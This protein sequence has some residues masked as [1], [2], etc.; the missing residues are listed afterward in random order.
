LT[1]IMKSS[2]AAL[3]LALIFTTACERHEQAQP[4]ALDTSLPPPVSVADSEITL[5][6]TKGAIR[7]GENLYVS[8][9]ADMVTPDQLKDVSLAE[10]EEEVY[11][12]LPP[13]V[14]SPDPGYRFRWISPRRGVISVNGYIPKVAYRVTLRPGLCDAGGN[15][16]N[17]A[18]WGAELASEDIG[19]S[20]VHLYGGN[21]V[22]LDGFDA[23]QA[24]PALPRARIDFNRDVLPSDVAERVFF[25]DTASSE[26]QPVV[27]CL[28]EWETGRPQGMVFVQPRKPLAVGRRYWLVV[29]RLKAAQGTYETSYLRVYPAGFCA[30]LESNYA[31]GYNQPRVGRFARVFFNQALDPG[32][33]DP[34][35]IEIV[36][37]VPDLKVKAEGLTAVLTGDFK[38]ETEYVIRVA[39]GAPA[40]S[41]VTTSEAKEW[42]ID[43]PERRPS[44]IMPADFLAQRF[45]SGVDINIAH[46]GTSEL[47]WRIAPVP[48]DKLADIRQ[49]LREFALAV[50]DDR[51]QIKL[52]PRDQ[53]IQY[54]STDSL[55]DA[56]QL[57]FEKGVL[58]A[59][60]GEE[61]LSHRIQWKPT[62]SLQL[63][64]LYLLE[65]E[66]QGE[67]GRVCGNRMLLSLSDWFMNFIATRTSRSVR[68]SNLE[69]GAPAAGVSVQACGEDGVVMDEAVTDADGIARF[70]KLGKEDGEEGGAGDKK[71]QP[72]WLLA[73]NEQ[74]RCLQM[75][76]YSLQGGNYWSGSSSPTEVQGMLVSNGML[77]EPGE[78]VRLFAMVRQAG[79]AGPVVPP[80]GFKALIR[81][82]VG[83]DDEPDM[84]TDIRLNLDANG[85]TEAVWPV[86]PD[87]IPSRIYFSLIYEQEEEDSGDLHQI[88]VDVTRF[89]PPAFEVTVDAGPTTGAAAEIELSSHFF[90]GSANRDATATWTA[91]WVMQDWLFEALPEFDYGGEYYDDDD[92]SGTQLRNHTPAVDSLKSLDF[93]ASDNWNLFTFNDRFSP[94]AAQQGLEGVLNSMKLISGPRFARNLAA[95][96]SQAVRGEVK[97]DAEGKAVITCE[98]PF[99]NRA[100]SHRAQVFWTIDVTTEAGQSR[101]A[102]ANQRVQFPEQS[103]AIRSP[104]HEKAQGGLPVAITLIDVH[105]EEVGGLEAEV[106]VFH[107]T[108][109]TVVDRLSETVHRYRNAPEFRTVSKQK[110]RLPFTG[111]LPAD[112]PGD[113]VVR[114]SLM[115]M[116]ESVPASV[117]ITGVKASTELAVVDNTGF[118]A[119]L[120]QEEVPVGENAVIKVRTPFPGHLRITVETGELLET[121]PLVVMNGTES[122]VEVPVHPEYFPNVFVRLHLMKPSSPEEPPAERFALCP[123]TVRHPAIQLS[124]VPRFDK[125]SFQ[126]REEVSGH[127]LVLAGGKPLAKAAVLVFAVDDAVHSLTNWQPPEPAPLFYP[128]RE[129]D[130]RTNLALGRQW[131]M[132]QL[133]ELSQFEKGYILGASREKTLL[134]TIILRENANP[135]PLWQAQVV[136]DEQGR[137]AFSFQAPDSLTSYRV[138]AVAH[139]ATTQ[140]GAGEA[141]VSVSNPLRVEPFLPQFIR[142]G[143]ELLVRCQLTQDAADSAAVAL[144]IEVEGPASLVEGGQQNFTLSKG[145]PLAATARLKAGAAAL[146]SRVR[147]IFKVRTTSGP[148]LADGAIVPLVLLPKFALRTEI[149]TGELPGGSTWQVVESMKTEWTEQ[150]GGVVDVLLS[151][152]KWLPQIYSMAPGTG[153]NGTMADLAS[154]AFTPYLV[155]ELA[156]YLPWRPDA[157]PVSNEDG[158][159]A[160]PLW[161]ARQA[162]ADA[163]DAISMLEDSLIPDDAAGWLPRFPR[164]KTVDDP[165]TALVALAISVGRIN[166]ETTSFLDTEETPDAATANEEEGDAGN[167]ALNSIWSERLLTKL[168]YW[169]EQATT[170]G[171][172]SP[173]MPAPTPFVQSLALLADA[174]DDAQMENPDNLAAIA[175]QLYENREKDLGLEGRCF[176]ALAAARLESQGAGGEDGALFSKDQWKNL[177]EEIRAHPLPTGL[178][179]STLSTPERATAIRVYTLQ[180][181]T[182]TDAGAELALTSDTD[183]RKLVTSTR[184]TTAQE[185][186]WRLLATQSFIQAEEPVVIPQENLPVPGAIPSANGVTVGWLSMPAGEMRDRFSAPL[187]TGAASS[188]LLRA[189]YRA[190]APRALGGP[191]LNLV[192]EAASCK[193][194]AANGAPGTPFKQG[195]YV[196][197]TYRVTCDEPRSFIMIEEDLPAALEYVNT[198]LEVTRKNFKLPQPENEVQLAYT[199]SEAGAL[200]LV[201]EHLPAGESVCS[202]LTQVVGTGTFSW[203]AA[204][205]TPLYDQRIT[206]TT[207]DAEVTAVP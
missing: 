113:Y 10:S 2:A 46:S 92:G 36:P 78:E 168:A 12:L 45:S 6:Q 93:K 194:Q 55:I 198:E 139:T 20:E 44:V 30:P 99:A 1:D 207:A 25:V 84:A 39:A 174:A 27:A 38:E 96:A 184:P 66:G 85:A 146:D 83:S 79:A 88:M 72:Q 123:L 77:Y 205:I 95:P 4:A 192:R 75:G 7:G 21:D 177:I 34:T 152:T 196:L 200:R 130:V 82:M 22:E 132:S 125:P 23:N 158:A 202:V 164:S 175:R 170:P 191:K 57:S 186:V 142:E 179:E 87:L 65:V 173:D 70:A 76:D 161:F 180:T 73:G 156:A 68:L 181:L 138:T 108:I 116:P 24:L 151:G 188:W 13:V 136:T 167:P 183:A 149:V 148:A 120:E 5:S 40:R 154:A 81:V 47:T 185:N 115:D 32:N 56:H 41:G 69:N 197:L 121:L 33:F 29:E 74:G 182:Q 153:R 126:P 114:A 206:S 199:N 101:R 104:S 103:L 94:S 128:E 8:F 187:P 127:V 28:E 178:E 150:S 53:T 131:T 48:A 105:D 162:R 137:A 129:H 80:P 106:E 135:R 169:R 119:V 61:E 63:A 59:A 112:A 203:P 17:A 134:P 204:R 140:I 118:E 97:L 98:C 193:I 141:S 86:P 111:T 133:S 16:V 107:R 11:A 147:V 3:I 189:T 163:S 201:I 60:P 52:D 122:R 64:G 172:R 18:G 159:A 90:H 43:I 160:M 9:P 195:D 19:I 67:D 117:V 157:D 71:K 145:T 42:R 110:V 58:P 31:R 155:P 37:S 171:Y 51:N 190:A 143:D 176:V 165:T 14:I 26:R 62:S 102:S 124:V 89:R 100:Q 54:K 49:R 50:R 109:N 144:S 166:D 91:E 35:K 15:P